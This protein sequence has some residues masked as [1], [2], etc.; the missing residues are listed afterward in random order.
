MMLIHKV[1][2]EKIQVQYEEAVNKNIELIQ[3]LE[4]VRKLT[5]E[6][7]KSLKTGIVIKFFSREFEI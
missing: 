6:K 2:K 1:E 7:L 4:S 3:Q 5:R